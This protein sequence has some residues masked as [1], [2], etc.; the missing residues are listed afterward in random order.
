MFDTPE[1]LQTRGNL[2][3]TKLIIHEEQGVPFK[4]IDVERNEEMIP[5]P[6]V[7]LLKQG[8]LYM[9]KGILGQVIAKFVMGGMPTAIEYPQLGKEQQQRVLEWT[10]TV[11]ENEF[12]FILSDSQEQG[13]ADYGN[14]SEQDPEKICTYDA[15]IDYI[16][17][18]A[19]K[20][21]PGKKISLFDA[22]CGPI[23]YLEKFTEKLNLSK[24]FGCDPVPSFV[25]MA[26][27]NEDKH[28]LD[29]CIYQGTFSS[30]I[31][32]KAQ[33]QMKE[34]G[35]DVVTGLWMIHNVEIQA[36]VKGLKDLRQYINDDGLVVF[37]TSSSDASSE[38]LGFPSL[39]DSQ[40]IQTISNPYCDY[41]KREMT[42][43]LLT[44]F[45]DPSDLYKR[46][47][48]KAGF[49]LVAQH[50]VLA[51]KKIHRFFN[52]YIKANA[53][54]IFDSKKRPL[55]IWTLLR[56]FMYGKE[57]KEIP[58]QLVALRKKSE[59]EL[60]WEASL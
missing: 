6:R 11:I 1:E 17:S 56:L 52:E 9:A 58:H 44:F 43:G 57:G 10:K 59:E 4:I 21:F 55:L 33:E 48:E 27:L 50:P 7:E 16:A 8:R 23:P 15:A 3:E 31:P 18:H 46:V 24:V 32:Q 26:R 34:S 28:G 22:G 2:P 60:R 38:Y 49:E 54:D 30:P 25:N 19:Q 51:D 35:L 14:F 45:A 41:Q 12:K 5:D 13:A 36:V 42:R 37:I 40:Q 29:S 47:A 20:Y 53:L 39:E